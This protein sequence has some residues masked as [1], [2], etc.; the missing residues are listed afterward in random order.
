MPG[1]DFLY[2]DVAAPFINAQKASV[3]L[4]FMQSGPKTGLRICIF[5]VC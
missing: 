5:L 4:H 2:C 1:L 3:G